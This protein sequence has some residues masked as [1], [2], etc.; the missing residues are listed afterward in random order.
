M[1]GWLKNELYPLLMDQLNEDKL[2]RDGIFNEKAVT[3]SIK[4]FLR[5]SV[6]EH[7]IWYLLMFQMWKE[8]WL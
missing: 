2:K 5:G 1:S 3:Q 6:S 7:K 4:D 8:R